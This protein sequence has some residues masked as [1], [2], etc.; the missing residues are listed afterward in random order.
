M[1]RLLPACFLAAAA[2]AAEVPLDHARY[3]AALKEFRSQDGRSLATLRATG[4]SAEERRAAIDD[5]RERL[6]STGADPVLSTPEQLA[7][8]LNRDLAKW[9]KLIRDNNI[10]E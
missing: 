5:V 4:K 1:K 2:F 9:G 8:L 6:V 7:E 10:T 3:A